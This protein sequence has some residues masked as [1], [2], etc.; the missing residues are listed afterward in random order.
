MT[1]TSKRLISVLI[2]L[3]L[4]LAMLPMAVFAETATT[5]Y[6][7]PNSN[8]LTDGARFA[9]YFFG[10]GE[11]W[12]D[13]TDADGDGIYEVA[14]P[15]GYPSVIFCRMNP[16]TTE[17][18]WDNKWNQTS[19]LTVPSDDKICYVVVGWDKGAG[20]WIE[21]GGEVE[22]VETA[23]YLVGSMNG[24]SA[25]D[26]NK[27]TKNDDG[28]YSIS[29]ELAAGDY[30]YK[31]T[32]NTGEWSPDP[33]MTLTVDSD[34]TV[35]FT[36]TL[37][38][39][40]ASSTVTTDVSGEVEEP[41]EPVEMVIDTVYAVGAGSGNFLYGVEWN[42]ASSV[43]AMT[44]E[45]GVYTITYMGVAAGTYEYK[46]AANG[47]WTINW[48]Y[49]D[50]TESGTSY[51]AW[52]NNSNNSKVV[53]EKDNSTVTL[54]L[55][56]SAVNLVDGSGAKMSVEVVAPAVSV[57]PETLVLGDNAWESA[58][59]DTNALTSTYTATEDGILVINPTAMSSYDDYSGEWSDCPATYIPMQLAGFSYTL[60]VNGERV[61]NFPA[62]V[63]V[64]AGDEVE[65]GFQSNMGAA[66]KLTL[67][68][69]A[70]EPGANEIKWQ[71]ANGATAADATTD[72]RFVT[73]VD[74][75]DYQNVTFTITLA[76]ETAV[77]DC[78]TVYEKLIAGDQTID[79]A[80]TVFGDGAAYFVAFT[81]ENLPQEY[82]NSEIAV[83][84]TWTDLEGNS[85]SSETRTIVVADALA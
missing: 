77:Y 3:T 63:V 71:V 24:W 14:V 26:S 25:A 69:S 19:D 81:M 2:C 56:L 34:R 83:T 50:V 72:V 66:T 62:E 47:D 44:E 64:A 75:L 13:C 9:A 67:N 28:T 40:L 57:V 76:G 49:G 80:A 11:T 33:N 59:G 15:A 68:L 7:Q 23:Y 60:T 65:I 84:V 5:I 27:M 55:D 51:D 53:V 58:S 30:E 39:D 43:N 41:E 36:L 38:A 1:K 22:P 74:S 16:A 18:N 42:P 10:N 21:M 61:L 12:L 32:T 35:T 82:Y 31:I 29:M 8:W 79:S 52:F 17:N 20:Q 73:S 85:T 48:S 54:T 70:R 37:G 78:E 4:V 45:N 6:V 46:Y